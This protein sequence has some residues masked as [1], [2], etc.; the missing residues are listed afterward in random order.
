MEF[1]RDKAF[2]IV[3]ISLRYVLASVFLASGVG[4]L[5]S[6]SQFHTFVSSIPVLS[7]VNPSV[8]LYIVVAIEFSVAALLLYRSTVTLGAITSFIILLAFS[9]TL[10]Y[11][12]NSGE[13]ISCGCFGEL[14]GDSSADIS[15]LKNM[16][17]LVL[18]VFVFSSG[19]LRSWER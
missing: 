4:K 10:V 19:S 15:I 2:L 13:A 11:A 3:K 14:V 12:S 1:G 16:V 5:I 6:P 7:V 17:L 18:S 8:F 9:A